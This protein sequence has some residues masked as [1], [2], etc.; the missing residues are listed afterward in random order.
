MSKARDNANLTNTTLQYSS[1]RTDAMTNYS[2]PV[3]GNGQKVNEL[4]ITITPKYA[5]SK[6]IVR[7]EIQY[8]A[9]YNGGFVV[10]KNGVLA[11]NGYNTVAG[12]NTMNS[13]APFEYDAD[14]AS[15]SN[16]TIL[17]Y[18]DSPGSTSPITYSVAGRSSDT[19]SAQ[20]F[21][22]NRT[23]SNVN[24]SAYESGVSIGEIWEIAQ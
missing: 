24:A 5:N 9:G 22:L 4:D 12:N 8:E 11:G 6:I 15:T 21:W 3:Y 18:V 23:V 14:V 17:T 2:M 13:Y 7:W 19:A 10:W 16:R 20:N 1:I